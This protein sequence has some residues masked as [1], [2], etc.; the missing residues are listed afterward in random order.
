MADNKFHGRA[1]V[2]NC[3][4]G[5]GCGHLYWFL[6]IK[7]LLPRRKCHERLG[8]NYIY[9]MFCIIWQKYICACISAKF[10]CFICASQDL[11]YYCLLKE[12]PI[13]EEIF[14]IHKQLHPP[15]RWLTNWRNRYVFRICIQKGYI[16]SK[17]QFEGIY[18][19]C[20]GFNS[21]SEELAN[22][23]I[24]FLFCMIWLSFY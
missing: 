15:I 11:I 7:K 16:L 23:Y 9:S 12:M 5:R 6:H 22:L 14:V 1:Q 19:K 24:L 21:P 3:W 17:I 4:L 8:K 18:T 20:T 2:G 10:W 13:T